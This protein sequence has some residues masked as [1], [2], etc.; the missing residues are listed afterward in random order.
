MT[1]IPPRLNDLETTA[2]RPV[3][4]LMSYK[5]TIEVYHSTQWQK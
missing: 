2:S 5:M 1:L 3:V 4:H